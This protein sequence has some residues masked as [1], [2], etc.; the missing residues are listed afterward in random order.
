V[1]YGLGITDPATTLRIQYFVNNRWT[2]M[3]ETGTQT[4]A[5]VLF[6]VEH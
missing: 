2:L 3:A 4:R 5:D 1:N 6:T